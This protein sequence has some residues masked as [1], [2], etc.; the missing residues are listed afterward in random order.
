MRIAI[1]W[2]ASKF[3]RAVKSV[4]MSFLSKRTAERHSQIVRV[5]GLVDRANADDDE[6]V[7]MVRFDN[8]DPSTREFIGLGDV[9]TFR[10][11]TE[12]ADGRISMR[13][14]R[15]GYPTTAGLS[16]LS[17]GR[18]GV[19]VRDPQYPLQ[20]AGDIQCGTLH[21][22]KLQVGGIATGTTGIDLDTAGD[23]RC[24]RLWTRRL[25]SCA[26][27]TP[28]DIPPPTA[29]RGNGIDA[30]SIVTVSGTD[31]EGFLDVTFARAP[32]SASSRSSALAAIAVVVLGQ[33][34]PC[35]VCL[36]PRDTRAASLGSDVY[37]SPTVTGFE[38]VV[39]RSCMSKFVEGA[40]YRWSFVSAG[41]PRPPLPARP[42]ADLSAQTASPT[43]P[44]A[45]G[46]RDLPEG[47]AVRIVGTD[48]A[49][50][51]GV[52]LGAHTLPPRSPSDGAYHL[53]TVRF[54]AKQ[55]DTTSVCA[56]PWGQNAIVSAVI[57]RQK[58][59]P[60]N[61]A[62]AVL[63][64]G[65]G[66]EIF[67]GSVPGNSSAPYGVYVYSYF[68]AREEPSLALWGAEAAMTAGSGAVASLNASGA[69]VITLI[70]GDARET[71]MASPPHTVLATVDGGDAIAES[72]P[73]CVC[74]SNAA[75]AALTCTVFARVL[76]GGRAVQL[77]AASTTPSPCLLPHTEYKWTFLRTGAPRPAPTTPVVWAGRALA[78]GSAVRLNGVDGAGTLNVMY[79]HRSRRIRTSRV[80]HLATVVF[81][82]RYDEPVAVDLTCS[83]LDGTDTRDI[84]TLIASP[85]AG[86]AGFDVL[87]SARTRRALETFPFTTCSWSYTVVGTSL[88]R[89]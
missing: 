73:L 33:P 57:A 9:C 8:Y 23:V 3:S 51:I 40:T 65:S 78:R 42:I 62:A 56:S 80:A 38:V 28:S 4:H 60:S 25:V 72:E 26:F 22:D 17:D 84:P 16:I 44:S 58:R 6:P 45:M 21:S 48:D 10:S 68:V 86:Y 87:A 27:P 29:L 19:G 61:I 24:R 81:S 49:G 75:S 12:P 74:A 2:D 20:V 35:A 47:A 41:L 7:A 13:P 31:R 1:P 15:A 14:Y 64:D 18:T 50:I 89:N 5:E 36:T 53:A 77:V 83:A 52:T 11:D 79:S 39:S 43:F 34:M 37:A 82:S 55:T 66:F 30:S 59:N 69:A 46:G 85:S 32:L 63:T 54:A 71:P 67:V 76:S 88:K 70:S